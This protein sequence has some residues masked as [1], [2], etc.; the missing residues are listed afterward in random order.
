ME[1]LEILR[2]TLELGGSDIF[3]VPG[4]QVLVKVQGQMQPVG[5]E[6][7]TCDQSEKLI[8][9]TSGLARGRNMERLL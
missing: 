9:Q 8:R 3:I 7:V 5:P 1:L 6:R 2:H 4:S